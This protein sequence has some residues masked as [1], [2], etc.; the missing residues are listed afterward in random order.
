MSEAEVRDKLTGAL[1]H[2]KYALELCHR[3]WKTGRMFIFEH[4]VAATSWGT[5]MMEAMA[6]L[7]GVQMVNFDFC[8]LGMKTEG[9]NGEQVP[10][11][12]RTRVL[13]NSGHIAAALRYYQCQ[14]GHKHR[15]LDGGRARACEQYP[16]EFSELIVRG[17]KQELEDREWA[18]MAFEK[19]K[20]AKEIPALMAITEEAEKRRATAGDVPDHEPD[21]EAMARLY[22][23][24]EFVDDLSGNHLDAKEVVKARLLEMRFFRQMGVYTKVERK[25]NMKAI[26]TKWLDINKGDTKS[27][28]YRSRLVGRELNLQKRD[29]LFA[30]TPPLESL[31]YIVSRCASKKG[32]LIMAIDIK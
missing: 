20:E 29:D 16:E 17:L 13:T 22:A 1:K 24:C 15:H 19:I 30:G 10:A 7:D 14:G 32:N 28:N 12:K 6:R 25:T 8:G 26:T 31:R 3:Q 9:E 11:R 5:K 21:A 4:P 18:K 2:L 23:G 27:P